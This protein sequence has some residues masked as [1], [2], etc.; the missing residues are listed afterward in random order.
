MRAA[1]PMLSGW[2]LDPAGNG[3]ARGMIMSCLPSGV[4]GTEPG[5][6]PAPGSL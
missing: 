5:L 6:C 2:S 1:R 3:G 4:Q